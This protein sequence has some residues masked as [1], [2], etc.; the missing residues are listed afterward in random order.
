MC[1]L[2]LWSYQATIVII[3]RF[4][5]S[6]H[7]LLNLDVS[8]WLELHML[9]AHRTFDVLVALQHYELIC[10]VLVQRVGLSMPIEHYVDIV[11]STFSWLNL[12]DS[13]VLLLLLGG[14]QDGC[15]MLIA[16]NQLLQGIDRSVGGWCFGNETLE[17]NDYRDVI[18]DS[19]GSH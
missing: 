10:T 16:A 18:I 14:L 7:M 17:R 4:S 6:E 2:N 9:S 11:K 15:W 1:E 19:P 12:V 13:V 5:P 8:T 3:D